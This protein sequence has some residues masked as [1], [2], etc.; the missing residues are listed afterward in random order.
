MEHKTAP[1][2]KRKTDKPIQLIIYTKPE[3]PGAMYSALTYDIDEFINYGATILYVGLAPR[4]GGMF[5]PIIEEY[6]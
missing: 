1:W 4:E 5:H 2:G 6:K 3:W